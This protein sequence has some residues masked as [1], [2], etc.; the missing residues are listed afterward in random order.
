MATPFT[1]VNYDR[2]T[3]NLIWL[4]YTGNREATTLKFVVDLT[5]QD[6]QG[7]EK[8]FHSESR[9][10]SKKFER[11][12]QSINRTYSCYFVINC[13]FENM[14]CV[15]RPSDVQIFNMLVDNN[16][17]P[18]FMGESRIFTMK[19]NVMRIIGN[20]NDVTLPL[21]ERSYIRFSPVVINYEN[22]NNFKEGIRMEMNSTDNC[23]DI[24]LD[25]FLE[26]AYI[27]KN[28]D[29]ITLAATMINYVKIPPYEVNVHAT[30]SQEG[31][32]RTTGV[33]VGN[34]FDK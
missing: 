21:S 24:T 17:M 32:T 2:I 27:L 3:D 15:L 31:P 34:F 1:F 26:M 14:G 11:Y 33:K 10:Y 7:Q 30:S 23:I 8:H 12:S 6:I 20:Y 13:G 28:T 9:Y 29:M 16:I 22:S 19:D 5:K 18:W 4:G 25:K